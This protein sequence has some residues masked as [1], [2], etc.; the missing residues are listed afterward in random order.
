[1]TKTR[2]SQKQ[3]NVNQYLCRW[4]QS[5]WA[6]VWMKWRTVLPRANADINGNPH[7]GKWTHWLKAR[8]NVTF[9]SFFINTRLDTSSNHNRCIINVNPLQQHTNIDQYVFAYPRRL[10]FNAKDCEHKRRYSKNSVKEH[11]HFVFH[12]LGGII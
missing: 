4:L 10:H 6:T 12:S 2:L 1:M 3:C 8:Y 11:N 7:K 5:N 9:D